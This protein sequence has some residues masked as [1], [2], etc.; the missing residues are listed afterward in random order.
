M[1]NFI[2]LQLIAV[3]AG[4]TT[5]FC[6]YAYRKPFSAGKYAGY[7]LWGVDFKILGIS[8]QVLGYTISKFLGIKIV[9]EFNV[10]YRG[11]TIFAMLTSSEL[12]L[13][14][15]GLIPPPYNALVMFLN[16]LPLGPIWGLTFSY[17]EG[18]KTSE[19]LGGGMA[20]SMIVASGAVKSVGQS[21]IL[22]GLKEFWMPAAV[23]AIFY[24]PMALSIVVLESL[25]WPNKEDIECRTER[26]AMTNKDRIKFFKTFWPGICCMVLFNMLLVA[27]RDFRDNFSPELW[28][29]FGYDETPSI[30]S[31]SEIIV[32]FIVC[33]PVGLFTLV[34]DHIKTLVGY[35]I[36]II[37]GQLLIGLCA[38]LN[39]YGKMPGLYYM[40]VAGVGLYF[41]YIPF[42]SI[43]FDSFIATFKYKANSGFLSYVCDS[44][45]YLSSV[46]ILFVKNFG[47]ADLSWLS[48]F[49]ILSYTIALVG[50]TFLL[51]SLLYYL[52]KYKTWTFP[53]PTLEINK[54]KLK[55]AIEDETDET[56]TSATVNNSD[57]EDIEDV[58]VEDLDSMS[59]AESVGDEAEDQPKA[60]L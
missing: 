55:N 42:N 25:P 57:I 47:S 48:F 41:G 19:L 11:L 18:R 27:F 50:F 43:I 59:L 56:R 46:V 13:I 10:K 12:V 33:I 7:K 1:G 49:R 9:S 15:F 37:A 20:I 24:I 5:Y 53:E 8:C 14:L 6:M 16:G 38:L 31:I 22:N 34:K 4:F 40:I 35:H 17:M 44:F 21:L 2:A 45:G 39:Y 60:A 28:E 26:V 52:Y 51:L 3:L 54:D 58:K 32:A 36:L 30:F 29:A 23:G